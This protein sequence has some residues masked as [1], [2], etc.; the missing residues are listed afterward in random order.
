ML[1]FDTTVKRTLSTAS[2][3]L[4]DRYFILIRRVVNASRAAGSAGASFPPTCVSFLVLDVPS[5]TTTPRRAAVSSCSTSG[6]LTLFVGGDLPRPVSDRPTGPVMK[7][8]LFL[9]LLSAGI[10]FHI[11]YMFLRRSC[12]P[13]ISI[14]FKHPTTN[15]IE[16]RMAVNHLQAWVP[17]YPDSWCTM[18]HS[19]LTTNH[20]L[21]GLRRLVVPLD[22]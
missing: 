3:L 2:Y 17:E 21:G 22:A 12:E 14:S 15:F 11:R 5:F 8:S 7:D 13:V 19:Q 18:P 1:Y 9:V 16:K 4:W 10:D 6:E 20:C